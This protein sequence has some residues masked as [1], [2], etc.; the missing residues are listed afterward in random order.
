MNASRKGQAI[1]LQLSNGS[2]NV[3]G[4]ENGM[5]AALRQG[6]KQAMADPSCK[7][8]ILTGSDGVFCGGADLK[9]LHLV[10]A[11]RD[12][13]NSVEMSKK[14]V[15]MAVNGMALG[16]GVELIMAGHYRIANA[17]ARFALPEVTMG[18]L[19]GVGGTQ[20]LPRLVGAERALDMML[21]GK[22]IVAKE[23]LSCA[24]IDIVVD[25]CAVE[26]ALELI[27][28]DELAVR[29]TSDLPV[30][31]DKIM[32]VKT[33][34]SIM[35]PVLNKAPQH[36]LDCVE[37][38]SADFASGLKREAE[39]FE[40]LAD[41]EVSKGLRYAFFGERT[42]VR[43]SALPC[44]V[45]PRSAT[46]VGV[47]GSIALHEHFMAALQKASL[48]VTVV[49]SCNGDLA[50]F[51]QV[52]LVIDLVPG[53]LKDKKQLLNRLEA[54]VSRDAM[55]AL[56]VSGHDLDV[57]STGAHEATRLIGFKAPDDQAAHLIEVAP[58]RATASGVLATIMALSKKIRKIAV[59]TGAYGAFIGDR[60]FAAYRRTVLS[61]LQVGALPRQ[62]DAALEDWGMAAGPV[63]GI[64][65]DRPNTPTK[66]QQ[67]EDAEI[68]QMCLT[69][70]IE[71]GIRMIE[72]GI[73]CRPVDIDV[74]AIHRLG[75]PRERGGPMFQADF[76][77]LK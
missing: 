40:K 23:A 6:L 41:S 10:G 15:V 1:V 62:I 74:V 26:A 5:V 43:V 36:I 65:I 42:V 67:I 13:L 24:L 39:F 59:V 54:V 68:I 19:P 34:R 44:E 18:L 70:M 38:M 71:E 66:G 33:R 49:E 30:P 14:P 72:E 28:A 69:A 57:L 37:G 55:L 77:R 51:A 53:S 47:V 46:S 8:V 27:D 3:L 22:T 11:M 63:R 61:L 21:L 16:G 2:A 45:K 25:G 17:G 29:R 76:L 64:G 4:I 48:D 56:N 7:A 35:K 9:E 12:F 60:I 32:A 20:R 75:F 50:A 58:C 73:A 31:P 52:D